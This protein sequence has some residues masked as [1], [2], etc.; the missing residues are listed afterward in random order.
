MHAMVA[1]E[2]VACNL[3]S[4]HNIAYQMRLMR[5]IRESI[6]CDKFPEFIQRFFSDLYPA[7]DVPR[8][9]VNALQSVNVHIETTLAADELGCEQPHEN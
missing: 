5:G 2:T 8:W 4:I 9:A 3:V 7:G 6:K 1:K